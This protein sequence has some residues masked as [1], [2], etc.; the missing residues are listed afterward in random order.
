MSLSSLPRALSRSRQG[1]LLGGHG[2]F[3]APL[4]SPPPPPLLDSASGGLGFVR[5]YLTSALV[6]RSAAANAP[7]KVGDWRS[8]LA[9]SQSR[10]LFC[11][12]SKK[13]Y[14]KSCPNGKEEPK[15]DGS[16]K[17]ESKQKFNSGSQW[18]FQEKLDK[19]FRF[20]A[21]V[22]LLELILSTLPLSTAQHEISFQEFK[23]KLL[24]PGLVD[25]IVVSNKEVA[26]V[27]VRSSPL[28]KQNQ[29]SD[30][31]ITT[32]HLPG[33]EAPSIYKYYFNIGSVDSFEEKLKEAQEALGIDRHDYIPVTYGPAEVSWFQEI[34]KLAPTVIILGLLYVVGKGMQS[35]FSIG[36]GS[37]KGGRS[38]FNIGKVQVT[39]MD[40]N[41]KDKVFFKDVVGCD[42][43]KQE[44]M[45][46]VHFLKNP[47]KYEELGAKIPKGALLVG[48]PGTGKTLLAK[49]TAG[50]S[51]VPFLSISGS[52]FM[53]MF[54][55]VGPSREWDQP[56]VVPT[57]C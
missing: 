28:T 6:H 50:E 56:L 16:D 39:K 33:K 47:K 35:G 42:E 52:D 17:S 15:G 48:P 41:S 40:K 49:A 26:K 22:F 53:K 14:D 29:D 12:Q 7:G 9:N 4:P 24:E 27:Y 19:L 5:R 34:L 55:G 43:A 45:E 10:R 51:G 44:I 57:Y 21:P 31:H 20:L 18:N 13:N 54:V 36:G 11:D 2:G 32:N 37:G 8:L 38:I 23:N 25:H 46:F 30:I 1:S 3:R